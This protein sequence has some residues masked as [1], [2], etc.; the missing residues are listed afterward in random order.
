MSFDPLSLLVSFLV[1]AVGFVA[2]MYGRKQRRIPQSVAG[3]ILMVY[4]YF[5]PGPMLVLLIAVGLLGLM[6]LAI[7]AGW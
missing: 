3:L 1:G 7:R 5:V 4:P 6:W 2:F